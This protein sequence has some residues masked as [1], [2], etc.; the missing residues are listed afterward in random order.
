MKI[1]DKYATIVGTGNFY[2]WFFNEKNRIKYIQLSKDHDQMRKRK[3]PYLSEIWY[4]NGFLDVNH[5]DRVDILIKILRI[6]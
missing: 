4:G 2:K 1:I 5:G 3:I 6:K